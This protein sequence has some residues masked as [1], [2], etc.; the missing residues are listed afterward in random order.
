MSQINLVHRKLQYLYFL[1]LSSTSLFSQVPI[2]ITTSVGDQINLSICDGDTVTFTLDPVSG[3]SAGYKFYRITGGVTINVQSN[4]PSNT[5]T[6]SSILYGDIFYGERYDYDF[7]ST[8][9]ITDQITFAVLTVSGPPFILHNDTFL[10]GLALKHLNRPNTDFSPESRQSLPIGYVINGAYEFNVNP[11]EKVYF[12]KHSFLLAYASLTKLGKTYRMFLSQELQLGEL[13]IGVNQQMSYLQNFSMNNFEIS[14]GLSLENFDIGLIY[15]FGV[16]NVNKVFA[17]G[18]FE[19][20]L[21]FDFSKFR[22]NSRGLFKRLQT[23]NY[24]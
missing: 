10:F 4:S 20:Y 17:P 7:S 5:Y 2:G 18:V 23:D 19:L 14:V 8:P 16:K 13:S 22:W 15:D 6:T 21:T 11:F 24:Y 12:P 1:L 3:T 9:I